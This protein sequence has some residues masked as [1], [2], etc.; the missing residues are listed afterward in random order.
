MSD[1]RTQL[2]ADGV[3]RLAERQHGVVSREQLR[4]H[5]LSDTMV[6]R[7]LGNGRLLRL[8]RRVFALGHT[9]LS[10]KG[11]LWAALLYADPDA[12]LSHTTAA[13]VW[14]LIQT[15]PARVHITVP[16]RRR[17]LPDVRVHH[18]RQVAV[19]HCRGFP[20]TP[21]ARTLVDLAATLPASQIRRALAEADFRG[22]LDPVD[23]ED[24]MKSG[25]PGSKALRAALRSHMPE[26]AETLSELEERFLELCERAQLPTPEVNARVG[27]MRVDALW[28]EERIAVELDGAAAHR[29]WAALRRDRRRELALRAA[30]FQVVRYS[31][32]Q[33]AKSPE[34]VFLDLRRLL[35]L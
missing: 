10:L 31:W 20:V 21:V 27:R 8:H 3:R 22:L 2:D 16:G 28:R 4:D 26:L 23:A 6:A 34:E 33:V 19:V 7:W 18:S 25:R 24:A 30:G 5:G 11:R 13:W 14:S 9:T 15:E 1:S 32:D 29:G 17:S 35:I 12:V